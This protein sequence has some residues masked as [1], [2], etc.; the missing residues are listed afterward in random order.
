MSSII[1][2]L[3]IAVVIMGVYGY[4]FFSYKRALISCESE[5]EILVQKNN[6]YELI[7]NLKKDIRLIWIIDMANSF[8]LKGNASNNKST[9]IKD[10]VLS[11]FIWVLGEVADLASNFLLPAIVVWKKTLRKAIDDLKEVKNNIPATLVGVLWIDFI[12]SGISR[13]LIPVYMLIMLLFG[14]ISYG[15]GVLIK[16]GPLVVTISQSISLYIPAILI[17]IGVLAV[18]DGILKTIVIFTKSVYFTLF[19]IALKK[20]SEIKDE[21]KGNLIN[22][23]VTPF[24]KGE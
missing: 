12:G 15:L 8:L 19:Y 9:S 13:I 1:G 20:P 22:Y 7:S 16:N 2:R 10:F 18:L 6:C 3:L 5:N 4:F 14:I 24:E 23:L 11:I 21:Y 17:G